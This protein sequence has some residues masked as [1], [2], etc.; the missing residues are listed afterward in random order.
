M[1]ARPKVSPVIPNIKLAILNIFSWPLTNGSVSGAKGCS[2]IDYVVVGD[3]VWARVDEFKVRDMSGSDHF[4]LECVFEGVTVFLRKEVSCE[5]RYR[6]NLGTVRFGEVVSIEQLLECV[7]KAV[8]KKE[9]RDGVKTRWFDAECMIAKRGLREVVSRC[10]LSQIS[11]MQ[12]L[13]EQGRYERTVDRKKNEWE[14]R[15]KEQGRYERTV[16]RK[17]NEWE[18]REIEKI[19]G[20]IAESEQWDLVKRVKGPR[21]N[22]AVGIRVKRVKGPRRNGAVGITMN[23]RSISESCLNE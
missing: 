20:I 15:E 6:E 14:E 10:R 11:R 19:R 9:R 16:D 17:K 1:T 8:C 23:G 7:R 3:N 2:V 4:P 18:E 21:R 12:L 22:G 5:V 13:Q